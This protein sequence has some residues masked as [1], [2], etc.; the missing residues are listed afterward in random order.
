MTDEQAND[1]KHP[2]DGAASRKKASDR[3]KT[4]LGRMAT[5]YVYGD[6][7]PSGW[8]FWKDAE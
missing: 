1:P 6:K 3:M 4:P 5:S 2:K 8:L 7:Y